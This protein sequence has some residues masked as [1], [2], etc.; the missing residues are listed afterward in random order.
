MRLYGVFR[1][2]T[3]IGHYL[4]DLHSSME[5]VLAIR[6]RDVPALQPATESSLADMAKEEGHHRSSLGKPRSSSWAAAVVG[7]SNWMRKYRSRLHRKPGSMSWE[8]GNTKQVNKTWG[9]I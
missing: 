3:A 1:R 9:R 2:R 8:S 7:R 4:G 5:S 6:G